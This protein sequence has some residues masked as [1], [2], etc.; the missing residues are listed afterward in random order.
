[1]DLLSSIIDTMAI[2]L[3]LN[4][5][6]VVIRLEY[7]LF[8]CGFALSEGKWQLHVCLVA[9]HQYISAWWCGLL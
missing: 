6:V 8:S 2:E 4:E 9:Q 5:K 3:W 7:W 1:M